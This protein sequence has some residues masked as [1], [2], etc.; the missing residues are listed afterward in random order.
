MRW[1]CLSLDRHDS[2]DDCCDCCS[3]TDCS[4]RIA[5]HGVRATPEP[6]NDSASTATTNN[7]SVLKS[8]HHHHYH[9]HNHCV[10][11]PLL[12]LL[13]LS[14][15]LHLELEQFFRNE[16]AIEHDDVVDV[17]DSVFM[18]AL[19]ANEL[20]SYSFDLDALRQWMITL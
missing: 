12:L 10:Y 19:L 14:L 11:Q 7:Y 5:S 16:M 3:I 20:K 6:Q 15:P 9:H 17:N 4:T 13:P 1:K 2:D 18:A 8:T